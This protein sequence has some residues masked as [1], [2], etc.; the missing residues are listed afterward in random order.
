VLASL[1]PT[2]A[3]YPGSRLLLVSSPLGKSDYHAEQFD[4]G[5]AA[6][7]CVAHAPS[8]V[9]NPTLSERET[10][11]L[12]PDPRIWAREYAAIPQA[13]VLS[14]FEPDDVER[15]FRRRGDIV[16]HF[17]R[18]GVI[19]ASSGK[20]DTF[21][22]GVV[23]WDLAEDDTRVMTFDRIGGYAPAEVRQH[24]ID[25]IV[26]VIA[27]NVKG[28]GG[29]LIFADQRESMALGASFRRNGL[30]FA[31]LPW[32]ASSKPRGVARLRRL[33]LEGRV[34][35]PQHEGLKRELHLF[36]ERIDSAGQIT[37]AGHAG[38]HLSCLIT[39]CLADEAKRLLGSPMSSRN[40]GGERDR[41]SVGSPLESARLFGSS[42]ALDRV[43]IDQRSGRARVV[44]RAEAERRGWRHW[45]GF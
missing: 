18:A 13:G 21:A 36:E 16:R 25:R 7:Q 12:E 30:R 11:E 5:E 19:D 35:L 23:G 8:W 34:S 17:R 15:A 10:H 44:P 22:W 32:T 41:G 28:A 37:F 39:A 4:R 26:E 1:R 45:G 3:T 14:A 2:L 42:D 33:L 24:G 38:D 9:A 29:Q 40:G 31:E 6:D 27:G 20:S 43:E